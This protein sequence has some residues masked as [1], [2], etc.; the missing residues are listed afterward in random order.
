MQSNTPKYYINY[1]FFK[2]D[3]HTGESTRSG[4]ILEAESDKEALSKL[5]QY[6][7]KE[8]GGELTKVHIVQ[9]VTGLLELV[10]DAIQVESDLHGADGQNSGEFSDYQKHNVGFAIAHWLYCRK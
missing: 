2:G 3:E 10:A 7:V 5:T 9:N 4:H 1:T 6:V 8:R